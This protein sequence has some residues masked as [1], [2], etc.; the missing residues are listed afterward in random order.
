MLPTPFGAIV[1]L[2][3]LYLL[4][5]G[6]M[7]AMLGFV[8]SCTL[9]G[10]SAAIAMPALGGSTIPPAQL[11]LVFLLLRAVLPGPGQMAEL[12]QAIRR[13]VFLIIYCLYGIVS[14]FTLPLLFQDQINVTPLKPGGTKRD[15]FLTVPLQ[16]TS[17]NI[18]TPVYMMGTM[19]AG[20]GACIAASRPGAER[21]V[22]RA[23]ATIAIVHA[24]LGFF[25]VVADGTPLDYFIRFFRNGNYAQL[26]QSAG[27]IARM[28]GIW[29][30]ASGFAAY[31]SAMML[32]SSEMWLRDIRPKFTGFAA[33][34]LALALFVSTS[35]TAYVTLAGYSL[36]LTMR[37]L[38]VPG[39][40]PPKKILALC[41]T[42]FLAVT[43]AVLLVTVSP[44]LFERISRVLATMTVE[45][46]DSASGR[47]RLFWALQGLDAFRVSWGLG[48]GAGSFRSSSN[49]LAILGSLGV[50]GIVAYFGHLLSV[51]RPLRRS[52]WHKPATLREGVGAAASWA[53]VCMIMPSIV[54][55]P[56]PDPGIVW[57]MFTGIA[58]GLRSRREAPWAAAGRPAV[59]RSHLAGA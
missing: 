4:L 57:G 18:T 27:G 41:V 45:K 1:V 43:I 30:E 3:G 9:F 12:P 28:N 37:M 7:A 14:A 10:G 2:I 51:L 13:N 58:L 24:L 55:A 32:F 53:A 36:V 25:S 6:S 29:P 54:A 5:R 15:L 34:I 39:S 11:S 46:S 38:L 47:Q 16:F 56:S 59:R 33:A 8:M 52:T 21:I 17:Q 23:G 19:I 26:D 44:E 49:L 22:I 40:I 50:I 42:I 20:V 35:S 31:G 48:I